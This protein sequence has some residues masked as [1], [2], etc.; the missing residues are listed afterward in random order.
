MLDS[1]PWVPALEPASESTPGRSQRHPAGREGS[2]QSNH[3]QRPTKSPLQLL[4][5]KI[6]IRWGIAIL[7]GKW[8]VSHAPHHH[9]LFDQNRPAKCVP[10]QHSIGAGHKKER[11]R[12]GPGNHQLHRCCKSNPSIQ[13]MTILP[14]L[15]RS[16]PNDQQSSHSRDPQY[17][18]RTKFGGNGQP[19][20]CPCPERHRQISALQHAGPPPHSQ[21]RKSCTG[22]IHRKKMAQL[23]CLYGKG[24]K[25]S[26]QQP[27]CSSKKIFSQQKEKKNCQRIQQRDRQPPRHRDRVAAVFSPLHQFDGWLWHPSHL[28]SGCQL[29]KQLPHGHPKI[30]R[31]MPVGKTA[32]LLALSIPQG[33]QR[34]ALRI[35]KFCPAGRQSDRRRIK[36]GSAAFIGVAADPT[37]K[38]EIPNSERQSPQQN[39]PKQRKRNTSQPR[40]CGDCHGC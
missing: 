13:G 31:K 15:L 9:S 36:T 33:I 11:Q 3:P 38:I 28:R 37:V 2:D 12:C 10:V 5:N 27:G 6:Q 32:R 39:E 29:L 18:Q 21:D 7:S 20:G 23:N 4:L 19:T 1:R 30:K 16:P 8:Q 22:R 35:P 26:R 14:A 40:I 25:C 17:R 34:T 24:I